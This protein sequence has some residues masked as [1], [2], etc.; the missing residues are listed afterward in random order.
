MKL[1]H[2]TEIKTERSNWVWSACLAVPDNCWKF[3]S[4][5]KASSNNYDWNLTRSWYIDSANINWALSFIPVNFLMG[6]GCY[7][8]S[9][10]RM[11]RSSKESK[12]G[13]GARR[14]RPGIRTQAYSDNEPK[15]W[16]KWKCKESDHEHRQLLHFFLFF[17]SLFI[18]KFTIL[19]SFL[20]YINLNQSHM[21][22]SSW[23]SLP[24]PIL[25]HPFRLSQSPRFELPAS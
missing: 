14:R 7:N 5:T 15:A 18:L 1:F 24:R 9:L 3:S 20:P 23:T 13:T 19:C 11:E 12:P 6:L 17:L 21:P 10:N 25:S 16:L 2:Q 8:W 22:P 4:S